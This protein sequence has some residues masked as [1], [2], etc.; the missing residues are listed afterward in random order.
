MSSSTKQRERLYGLNPYCYY[1]GKKT[2]LID[3]K[4]FPKGVSY[5]K[6]TATIEH[7]WDRFNKLRVE[8][9]EI[10][11]VISCVKCNNQRGHA[12]QSKPENRKENARRN[13]NGQR[14]KWYINLFNDID[15]FDRF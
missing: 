13:V 5:P 4:T 9:V 12:A 8:N 15:W 2:I 7:L 6:S 11:K 10:P 3:F 1:C 14:G